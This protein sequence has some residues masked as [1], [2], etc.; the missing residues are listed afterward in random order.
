M[1]LSLLLAMSLPVTVFLQD[2]SRIVGNTRIAQLPLRIGSSLVTNLPLQHVRTVTLTD[3]GAGQLVELGHGDP[4]RGRVGVSTFPLS[5]SLGELEL[6]WS[7][8]EELHV[9]A[10][11][12]EIQWLTAAG[13]PG[14]Q[15]AQGGELVLTGGRAWTQQRFQAPLVVEC[16][17]LLANR[18]NNGTGWLDIA[19]VA[20]SARRMTT[21]RPS[22]VRLVYGARTKEGVQDG[23]VL[24]HLHTAQDSTRRKGEA[25]FLLAPG[26]WHRLRFE[27]TGEGLRV[28][29]NGRRYELGGVQIPTIPVSVEL[30]SDQADSRWRV[31]NFAVR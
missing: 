8:V 12:G 28:L 25:P 1:T 7:T 23:V 2:G 19:L 27:V 15:L 18:V 4:L 21:D 26:V 13:M 29:L 20:D 9:D 10:P 31:R 14:F 30:S 24:R 17:V 6:P 3:D 11:T 5:T 16:E 22:G